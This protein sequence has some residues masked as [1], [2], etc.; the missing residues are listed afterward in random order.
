MKNTKVQP[1]SEQVK[2]HIISEKHKPVHIFYRFKVYEL[3]NSLSN[4]PEVVRKRN[5]Y[6]IEGNSVQVILRVFINRNREIEI[7]RYFYLKDSDPEL[8]YYAAM[9]WVS[10]LK[11]ENK[12]ANNFEI[13][14]VSKFF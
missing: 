7:I 2:Y 9:Y 5:T 12:L 3:A 11:S 6:Q 4:T 14:T 8:S 1:T 13:K 10:Y